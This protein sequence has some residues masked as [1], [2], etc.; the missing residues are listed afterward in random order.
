MILFAATKS[1]LPEQPD[2]DRV[3]E[4]LTAV[5]ANFLWETE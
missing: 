1:V 2:R 3:R 5:R 4:Y